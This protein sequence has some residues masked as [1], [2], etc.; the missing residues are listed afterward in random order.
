MNN[1]ASIFEELSK[2]YDEEKTTEEVQEECTE[3]SCKEELTEAAE[4]EIEI[5][6][7]E[8]P[9]EEASVEEPAVG[10]EPRQLILEC[11]NCGALI[12]KDEAN[13]V[14]DEETGLANVEDAC[15]YC[16]EAKGYKIV[17]VAIPYEA[18]EEVEEEVVE[19]ELS[20]TYYA[21]AEID[22]EER[23]FPFND[24]ESARKYV[25][26]IR[27][28][29]APEFKDKKVGSVWTEGLKEALRLEST[30]KQLN[31][32]ATKLHK[33]FIDANQ[34]F[35]ESITVSTV[36]QACEF[37][38]GGHI[39]IQITDKISDNKIEVVK[40]FAL[41]HLK[42]ANAIPEIAK[43]EKKNGLIYVILDN[44]SLAQTQTA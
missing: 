20:E 32:L 30:S 26:T 18:A 25:D 35:D 33:A 8:I 6:D 14:A 31:D 16:E 1:F 36:K 15:E 13:V 39:T 29:D 23:R 24:R 42:N 9:E 10:E 44:I 3:E 5:V 43:V 34:A 21:C 4:D 41:K 38:S 40:Q 37:G 22:G 11:D 27:S 7:D 19:E 28:G 12:I 17:G 2:L